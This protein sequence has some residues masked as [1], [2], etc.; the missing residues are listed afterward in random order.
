MYVI[1][2]IFEDTEQIHDGRWLYIRQ[3]EMGLVEDIGKQI[4]LKRKARPKTER[5]YLMVL[6]T[7]SVF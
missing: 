5:R 1:P 4:Q 2:N 3:P 6:D 7:Q